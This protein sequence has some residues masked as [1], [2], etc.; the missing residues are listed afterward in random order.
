MNVYKTI[1][2]CVLC[3]F[4]I[5]CDSRLP[6]GNSVITDFAGRRVAIPEEIKGVVALSSSSRYVVYLQAFDKVVGVEELEKRNPMRTINADGRMYWA[7]IADRVD[8][9][10]CIG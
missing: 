7:A 6:E 5:L 9:I 1:V 10:P 8:D 4:L 2:Y 3:L